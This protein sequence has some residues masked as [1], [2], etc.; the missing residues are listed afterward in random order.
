VTELLV[1]LAAQGTTLLIATHDI[2]FAR[3]VAQRAGLLDAGTLVREG[4]VDE[5]TR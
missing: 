3:D 4:T 2:P 1:A 5:V